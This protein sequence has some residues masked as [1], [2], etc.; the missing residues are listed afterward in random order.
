MTEER[1]IPDMVTLVED[2]GGMQARFDK[3]VA[4][5]QGNPEELI[6]QTAGFIQNDLLGLVKDL[7]ESTLIAVQDLEDLVD[8]VKISRDDAVG[9]AEILLATKATNGGNPQLVAK[10]DEALEALDYE[11]GTEEE[12]EEG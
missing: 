4:D 6:R 9:I 7:A 10:I 11:E 3:M 8:P 5:N 1:N 2:L 12:D